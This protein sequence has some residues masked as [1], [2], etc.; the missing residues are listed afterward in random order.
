MA[1]LSARATRPEYILTR[2][3]LCNGNEWSPVLPGGF[4]RLTWFPSACDYTHS[5]STG[6]R[7]EITS[8]LHPPGECLTL[9]GLNLPPRRDRQVPQK[10]FKKMFFQF[11]PLACQK[12]AASDRIDS[13]IGKNNGIHLKTTAQ[14]FRLG[15]ENVRR[16]SG[17][18]IYQ[19]EGRIPCHSEVVS[20]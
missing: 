15:A 1:F 2:L 20:W 12:T 5:Y 6:Y 8:H 7:F 16:V 10:S 3:K 13:L 17:R 14:F 9:G 19:R 4:P 11:F 18:E